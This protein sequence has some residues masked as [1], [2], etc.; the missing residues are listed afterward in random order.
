MAAPV[1]SVGL[2]IEL[3][4]HDPLEAGRALAAHYFDPLRAAAA[5]RHD[6]NLN[7]RRQR[8]RSRSPV[9]GQVFVR[10]DT[11]ATIA[12]NVTSTDTIGMLRLRLQNE[13]G[14]PANQELMVNY[15]LVCQPGKNECGLVM[16]CW[17][18]FNDKL[19]NGGVPKR[20][21]YCSDREGNSQLKCWLTK[22]EH[23]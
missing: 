5:G 2:L 22:A 1:Q 17:A 16:F 11:G 9:R 7:P 19:K 14:V 3:A 23:F 21:Y 8:S 10:T 6:L 13:R 12:L 18:I 15:F 4:L 20:W